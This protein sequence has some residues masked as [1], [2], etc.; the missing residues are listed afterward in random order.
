MQTP[1]VAVDQA[2]HRHAGGG[3]AGALVRVERTDELLGRRHDDV[4]DGRAAAARQPWTRRA[5]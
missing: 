3:D 1:A 5:R 4:E 2:G